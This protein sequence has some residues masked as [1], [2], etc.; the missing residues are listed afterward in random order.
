MVSFVNLL[1]APSMQCNPTSP[2]LLSGALM[3]IFEKRLEAN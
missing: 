1:A 3:M 2:F